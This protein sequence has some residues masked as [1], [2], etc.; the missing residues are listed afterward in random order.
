MSAME[1]D[2]HTYYKLGTEAMA[3]YMRRGYSPTEALRLAE[4]LM[5]ECFVLRPAITLSEA[6]KDAA[7]GD[8]YT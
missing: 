5:A 3:R 7:E 8:T 6:D 2:S 1:I 4:E